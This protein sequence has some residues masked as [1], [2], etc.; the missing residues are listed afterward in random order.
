MA[1]APRYIL[2]NCRSA[3]A[4]LGASIS[5]T[6]TGVWQARSATMDHPGQI[7]LVVRV[8]L[9]ITRF[10]SMD[11]NHTATVPS[12]RLFMYHLSFKGTTWTR[13]TFGTARN[14][15]CQ[16]EICIHDLEPGFSELFRIFQFLFAKASELQ[17]NKVI[18][19]IPSTSV[20][21]PRISTIYLP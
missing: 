11:S 15:R 4:I 13:R 18:V 21:F 19:S 17:V 1:I 5:R 10:Y 7:Q 9:G 16:G 6:P 2:V 8:E 12:S 20:Q 14:I 3:L